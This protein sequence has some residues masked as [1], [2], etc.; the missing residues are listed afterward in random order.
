[1]QLY[2]SSNESSDFAI[3]REILEYNKIVINNRNVLVVE[4][5]EPVRGQNHGL[6]GTDITRLYLVNRHVEDALA[7]D[8]LDKFPIHVYVLLFDGNNLPYTLKEFKNIAWACLYNNKEDAQ[9]HKIE[10][11]VKT[12]SRL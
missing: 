9:S 10:Y 4:V 3:P 7:F 5:D 6:G 1:M 11:V 12:I 8:N 2:L